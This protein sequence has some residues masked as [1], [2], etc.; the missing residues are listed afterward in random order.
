[1]LTNYIHLFT[2]PFDSTHTI[3]AQFPTTTFH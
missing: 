1:M 2:C 3:P